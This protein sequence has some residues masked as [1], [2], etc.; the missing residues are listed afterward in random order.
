MKL[1][2][3]PAVFGTDRK[4]RLLGAAL[5][6]SAALL[7]F[8]W[9]SLRRTADSGRDACRAAETALEKRV[10]SLLSGMPDL[11]RVRVLVT[12]E[13]TVSEG[14]LTSSSLF[15][16]TAS[17]G[18][19]RSPRVRGVGVICANAV[20]YERRREVVRL[21]TAAL[22]IGENRVWVSSG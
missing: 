7:L 10:V 18:A 19:L 5:I 2:G 12:L 20:S 4:K 17:G 1:Q 15:G 9:S 21:L 22:G 14:S 11:G 3:L 6:A 16:A 8:P 13:E